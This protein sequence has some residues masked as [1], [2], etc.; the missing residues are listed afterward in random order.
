M[1]YP[2]GKV[3]PGGKLI[4]ML[5]RYP[6]LYCDISAGS[7]CNALKRDPGFALDFLLEFQDRM[8]YARDYFDN[9][10]QEFLNS[11]DLPSAVLNKI[12]SGNAVKLLS[13]QSC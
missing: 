8:L 6:N 11:L 9:V 4:D 7:G 2:K 5:R 10:H 13:L 12:Y 1:G 3:E